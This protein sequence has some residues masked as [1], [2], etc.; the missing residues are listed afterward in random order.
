[1]IKTR[2]EYLTTASTQYLLR[3]LGPV[4]AEWNAG[5]DAELEDPKFRVSCGWAKHSSSKAIGSCFIKAV[6]A[7]DTS[8]IFISPEM[9]EPVLVLATL[10]HELIHAIDNAESGHKGWFAF[11][12]RRADLAGKLT[13]TV[14][15][16][17]LAEEL[18]VYSE[19]LGKYPHAAMAVN[20]NRKKQTT[21]MLKVECSDCGFVF[22]TSAKWADGIHDMS[23]CPV[24][25]EVG[26]LEKS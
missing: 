18:R 1:M 15:G 3:L 25:E 2:E 11:A 23:P 13:A 4:M 22:R 20:P 10:L 21:R 7:D 19:L 16:D 5:T 9:D 17:T 12:A 8:E 24:C 6:S 26:T 14:A